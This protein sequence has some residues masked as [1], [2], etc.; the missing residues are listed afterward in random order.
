MLRTIRI[1]ASFR[2][3]VPIVAL[4]GIAVV[5]TDIDAVWTR[6]VAV[7]SAP[8]R[9]RRRRVAG[10][11]RSSSTTWLISATRPRCS[12]TPDC[13]HPGRRKARHC[14]HAVRAGG[15]RRTGAVRQRSHPQC[16]CVPHRAGA[17]PP[18]TKRHLTTGAVPLRTA[19][20]AYRDPRKIA[21]LFLRSQAATVDAWQDSGASRP[22]PIR[23][24]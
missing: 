18:I 11:Q 12:S 16:H 20:A 21:T 9:I 23:H 22:D 19:P 6:L 7:I 17:T 3:I 10:W 4:G 24:R 13:G 15:N 8:R 1:E 2:G 14:R 5:P